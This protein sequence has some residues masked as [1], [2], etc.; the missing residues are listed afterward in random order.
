MAVRVVR[1][2]VISKN[3]CRQKH[4]IEELKGQRFGQLVVI[5][6]VERDGQGRARWLCHCDCGN[7]KVIAA[8]SLKSG[9]V[10]S[11]GCVNIKNAKKRMTQQMRHLKSYK[12]GASREPWYKC[13]SAMVNRVKQ[14]VTGVDNPKINHYRKL[15]K[16]K[17]CEIQWLQDPYLFISEIEGSYAPGL[18]IHRID[19][20][21]GY[22]RGNVKWAD[23]YEQAVF[24]D[25]SFAYGQKHIPQGVQIIPRNLSRRQQNTKYKA[26]ITVK[27][28]TYNLGT[29]YH[30]QYALIARYYAE[31][32]YGYGHHY[33]APSF[34]LPFQLC[35]PYN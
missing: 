6:Y 23:K 1:G 19:N 25:Y 17:L 12:N 24:R 21:R 29:F 9:Q 33:G 14:I 20:H 18:S 32:I 15:I 8:R 27:C 26:S 3:P 4:E 7:D 34:L 5:D 28:H 16:G 11:C 13:Y 31:C 10:I 35:L 22:V 2:T 30:L